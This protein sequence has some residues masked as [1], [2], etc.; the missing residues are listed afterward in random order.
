MVR[1]QNSKL[2]GDDMADFQAVCRVADLIEGEGQTFRVGDKLVAVFRL[3]DN[4]YAI[5][6]TC[7]HMGAALSE[8]F[9]EN[10]IVTCPWHAWRFRLHD[11][12]WADNPRIKIGSYQVRVV[13][14]MIE[15]E[16]PVAKPKGKPS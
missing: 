16:I 1:Y 8:G 14:E 13:G 7:P 10:G 3:G 2:W 6:N 11:G 15:V 12:V 4:F 5:D 9:V